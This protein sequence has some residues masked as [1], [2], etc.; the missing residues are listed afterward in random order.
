MR[1]MHK[2]KQSQHKG[3]SMRGGARCS[4]RRGAE[5]LLLL[6][7]CVGTESGKWGETNV[8]NCKTVSGRALQVTADT[9][10]HT[11][12]HTHTYTH[13]HTAFQGGTFFGAK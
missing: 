13:M 2:E 4:L 8:R 7:K 11:H 12:T 5:T 9:H 1:P 10:T 6:L 3:N